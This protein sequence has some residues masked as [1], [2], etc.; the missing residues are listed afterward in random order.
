MPKENMISLGELSLLLGVNKSS[1]NYYCRQG[2]L[3]PEFS[4]G[5]MKVFNKEKALKA[6]KKINDF[7]EKGKKITE[8]KDLL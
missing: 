1:L 4:A 8:I 2:L 5:R 6:F 7:K 3:I